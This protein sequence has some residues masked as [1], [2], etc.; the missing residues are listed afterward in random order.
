MPQPP[1]TPLDLHFLGEARAIAAF[2][3]E[4][5]DGLTLVEC[6]PYS[7]HANLLSAL[8]EN[9]F[10]AEDVHTVLLTHIH[11]DHAGAAWWWA[12]RGATVYVHPRG[13]RHLV[14]PTRLYDSA[15]QIYGDRMD[16]LWG[17]MERIDAGRVVAV[18][19][20]QELTLGGNR[21]VAHHTPGHASH[22]IAWQLEDT[23]F[24]GDVG[25]VKIGG[26]PVVPPCPPPDID[27]AAWA[28]SIHRL[29]ELDAHRF[30]LTHYGEITDPSRHLDELSTRLEKY[31]DWI[32]PHAARGATPEEVEPLFAVFVREELTAAGVSEADLGSYL[33]ANPPFMSAT[34]LL[35]WYLKYG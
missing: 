32:V 11:F 8:E 17:A 12:R 2:V 20:R 30:F 26:G 28:D 21:W 1:I 25:G 23:V 19:D 34:G 31:R 27:L 13:Q 16:E 9:G 29:R 22:H 35:R 4:D 24:T 3:I 5:T 10:N 7:T 6:G 18:E 15:R 14:D 33:A